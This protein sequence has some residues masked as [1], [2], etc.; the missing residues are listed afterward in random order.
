MN[1][2]S[3]RYL[4]EEISGL[5]TLLSHLDKNTLVNQ[6]LHPTVSELTLAQATTATANA[7]IAEGGWSY[8][9]LRRPPNLVHQ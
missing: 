9:N 6:F 7:V 5:H 1:R 8:R 3:P 4:R 2:L